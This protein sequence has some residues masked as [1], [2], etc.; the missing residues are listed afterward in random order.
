MTVFADQGAPVG[1]ST[2]QIIRLPSSSAQ[3]DFSYFQVGELSKVI[4]F[5]RKLMP[6]A[7]LALKKRRL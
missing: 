2:L 7:N 3:E 4:Q 1:V 6:P 5:D